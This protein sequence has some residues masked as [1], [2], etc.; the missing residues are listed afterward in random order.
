MGILRRCSVH[1]AAGIDD[2]IPQ[3]ANRMI[4]RGMQAGLADEEIVSLIT[5]LRK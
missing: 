3:F 2:E 1:S 4:K 5:L